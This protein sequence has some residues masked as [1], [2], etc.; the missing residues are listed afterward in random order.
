MKAPVTLYVIGCFAILLF[1]ALLS[2][3]PGFPAFPLVL[4]AV[5]FC[6]CQWYRNSRKLKS[7]IARET[8]RHRQ[9]NLY[10]QS[11][12]STGSSSGKKK[13]WLH[14]DTAREYTASNDDNSCWNFEPP[15]YT[16]WSFLHCKSFRYSSLNT[17]YHNNK[18]WVRFDTKRWRQKAVMSWS[19]VQDSR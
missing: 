12:I 8:K 5:I 6:S 9:A 3:H 1:T 7:S 14:C 16:H 2:S 15:W 13:R 18:A 11:L 10:I 17:R 4:I 19:V